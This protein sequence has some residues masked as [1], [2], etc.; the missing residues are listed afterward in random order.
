[1]IL[2]QA[3]VLQGLY[4]DTASTNDTAAVLK[5][6]LDSDLSIVSAEQSAVAERNA[7]ITALVNE[8]N[9]LDAQRDLLNQVREELDSAWVDW[10]GLVEALLGVDGPDV[11]LNK[12]VAEPGRKMKVT[13]TAVDVAAIGRFQD[14]LK[15]VSD[16][17]VLHNFQWEQS[18][19]S[20]MITAIVEVR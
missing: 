1:M 8:I 9:Q 13:A 17:L 20:L 14:H 10:G 15:S 5:T 3:V 2:V 11:R 6:D 12:V 4:R 19:S 16:I 7:K 18:D